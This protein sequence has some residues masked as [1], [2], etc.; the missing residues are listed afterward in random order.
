[1]VM[2]SWGNAWDGAERESRLVLIGRNLNA[3]ALEKSLQ[4]LHNT[5]VIP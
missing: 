4:R 3:P 5:A 1:M 2:D